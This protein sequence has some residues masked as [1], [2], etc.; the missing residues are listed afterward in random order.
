M[1]KLY[2]KNSSLKVN[3]LKPR[4]ESIQFLL[5][6]SKALKISRYKTLQFESFMN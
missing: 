6:Y 3:Y 2:S 5:N 1:A 4:K